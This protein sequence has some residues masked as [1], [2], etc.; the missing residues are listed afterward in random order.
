DRQRVVLLCSGEREKD[1]DEQNP[2]ERKGASAL[3]TR[4][5][6]VAAE[7]ER[8]GHAPWEQ[9]RE[10]Q[11]P[12]PDA[13]H[14]VVVPRIPHVKEAEEMLVK[15]VE[16]EEAVVLAGAGVHGPVETGWVAECSENVPRRCD[17]KQD[18]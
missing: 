11:Q 8:Q 13:G 18:C 4:G 3:G 10:V 5:L 7:R 1:K 17:Q 2:Y 6:G 12:E 14:G 16:P 15:E 9:P